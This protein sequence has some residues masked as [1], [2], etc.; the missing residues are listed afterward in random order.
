MRL[1][2]VPVK[3]VLEEL[4]IKNHSQLKVWMKMVSRGRNSP[5]LSTSW[6]AI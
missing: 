1:A 6:Q 2:G 4:N 5:T 3:Q